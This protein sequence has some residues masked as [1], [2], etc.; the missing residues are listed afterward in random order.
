MTDAGR[1]RAP[2]DGVRRYL[3]Y[4]KYWPLNLRPLMVYPKAL[5]P[6]KVYHFAKGRPH[7]V[8]LQYSIL[9]TLDLVP[10]K[11]ALRTA[12]T[13]GI[14]QRFVRG[15]PHRL[16]LAEVGWAERAP[17]G[18]P[19]GFAVVPGLDHQTVAALPGR[20]LL[21]AVPPCESTAPVLQLREVAGAVRGDAALKAGRVG[22]DLLDQRVHAGTCRCPMCLMGHDA[23]GVTI[24]IY[25]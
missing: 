7:P 24:T 6:L 20:F 10:G 17:V 22:D 13:K 25:A 2:D 5:F 18:P 8:N 1:V 4:L 23:R 16:Y 9:I 15:V 3:I 21:G 19:H 11:S 12:F 14:G